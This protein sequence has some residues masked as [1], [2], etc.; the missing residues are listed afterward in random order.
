MEIISLTEKIVKLAKEGIDIKLDPAC[1]SIL[2]KAKNESYVI[3]QRLKAELEG[4]M[5]KGKW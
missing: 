2:E 4:H 3:K 5:K 1:V